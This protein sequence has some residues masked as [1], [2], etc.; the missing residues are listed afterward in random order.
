MSDALNVTVTN[1][2]TKATVHEDAIAVSLVENKQIV[3]IPS[4]VVQVV[5]V[6][7]QGPP[8]PPGSA[9]QNFGEV[10]SGLI[11]GVNS[12][13]TTA[14]PFIPETVQVFLNGMLLI[15]PDEYNTSGNQTIVLAVSPNTGENLQ[16]NYTR[17]T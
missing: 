1:N 7:Q 13:F 12:T 3:T 8:G 10:P 11:D 9:L 14:D 17:L 2:E 4:T 16:V 15:K 6:A 5:E